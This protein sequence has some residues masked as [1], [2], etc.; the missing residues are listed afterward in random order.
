MG[1][2]LSKQVSVAGKVAWTAAHTLVGALLAV[3]PGVLAA[4]R[5]NEHGTVLT[6]A[7]S[8]LSG[9]AAFP[10]LAQNLIT[11]LAVISTGSLALSLLARLLS[12][13]LATVKSLEVFSLYG[14][15]HF[16]FKMRKYFS[17]VWTLS[18]H[19]FHALLHIPWSPF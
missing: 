13:V 16:Y 8:T 19:K 18:D 14:T 10:C 7:A 17:A 4:Q 3:A 11:V 1:A 5:A 12:V 6:A 9:T 15:D 2:Y